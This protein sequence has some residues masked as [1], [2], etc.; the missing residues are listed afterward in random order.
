[1]TAGASDRLPDPLVDVLV[2]SGTL[3]PEAARAALDRQVMH[4]GALDTALLEVGVPENSILAAMTEVYEQPMATRPELEGLDDPRALR[5]IPEQW[6]QRHRLPP[7]RLVDGGRTLVVLSPAPADL[8]LVARLSELLDVAVVPH[9]A[10]EVRVVAALSRLYGTKPP[11]RYLPLL[12]QTARAT[13]HEASA[14]EPLAFSEASARLRAP[15]NRH[16]IARALLG[17]A[18][19][20]LAFGS[21][22]VVKDDRLEG[23]VGFGA[24]SDRIASSEVPIAPGSA[25]R[26]VIESRA[27]YLG[28]S[29]T[30][31]TQGALLG[32]LGRRPPRSVL[33]VPLRVRNRVVALFHGENGPDAIPGR[34]AGD[35]MLLV[36][37][38]QTAF[39]QLLLRQ[40]AESLSQLSRAP[41]PG[42]DGTIESGEPLPDEVLEFEEPVHEASEPPTR[43]A[44]EPAEPQRAVGAVVADD[45]SAS[46]EEHP[47]LP[48]PEPNDAEPAGGDPPSAA[49][50]E[51]EA[52]GPPPDSAPRDPTA[53]LPD[54]PMPSV[55][56]PEEDWEPVE[57]AEGDYARGY[58]LVVPRVLSDDEAAAAVEASVAVAPED[59]SRLQPEV[60]PIVPDVAPDM[61]SD[62]LRLVPS[63]LAPRP[64][65]AGTEDSDD[66]WDVAGEPT[67]STRPPSEGQVPVEVPSPARSTEEEEED[68][69]PTFPTMRRESGARGDDAAR[70]A[71]PSPE[72]RS[73][74]PAWTAP[75][76]DLPSPGAVED[77]GLV[78]I[79]PPVPAAP[80]ASEPATARVGAAAQDGADDPLQGPSE[81]DAFHPDPPA[82]ESTDDIEEALWAEA[83]RGLA[84]SLLDE[85]RSESMVVEASSAE[86]ESEPSGGAGDSADRAET[87]ER[88]APAESNTWS[89]PSLGLPPIRASTAEAPTPSQPVLL[90]DRAGE[91]DAPDAGPVPSGAMESG[92]PEAAPDPAMIDRWLDRLGEPDVEARR[93]AQAQLAT[94][95]TA[96]LPRASDRFPGPLVVDPFQRKSV[97]PFEACGPL[98]G[99][100]A[101]L[102]PDAHPYVSRKLEAP[103]PRV[104]FYAAYFYS[105][106]HVPEVIPRLIQRLHDEEPRICMMAA[107]TLFGY[108]GHPDFNFVLE[109]LH[110]RL[111]ATSVAARRHSAYLIGLFR[112]VSAI[113]L[114]IDLL[115]RRDKNLVDVAQ[116]ALTEITKQQLGPRAS[117]WRSWL[118]RNRD[119]SRIAWLID[120]LSARDEGVRRSAAEELRAVTG[121]D[122]GFEPDA[123]RRRR[124][125]ARQ[126]WVD[127]W[128]R[129]ERAPR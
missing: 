96:I 68:D 98:L 79:E 73:D 100:I 99:L 15:A 128:A 117:K 74:D 8:D 26:V 127:W 124:E 39:E 10:L 4:G 81:P 65:T 63:E 87:E 60:P 95:G 126:K 103:D 78:E 85:P 93:E 29:P 90:V 57:V 2:R 69:E 16:D 31:D 18:L 61:G 123:P 106:A 71:S 83:G 108:R 12:V 111:S 66:L 116:D 121:Q 35:I 77:D 37:Q 45:A 50:A 67:V 52:D 55:D 104:R 125:E 19:R 44:P 32:A 54:E 11:A 62:G 107:R 46:L 112:D 33:M 102:G 47:T 70:P 51:T 89:A 97:P 48:E 41:E 25:A 9:L 118:E 122:F 14:P 23:W 21:L 114:L 3:T 30:D 75:T 58:E 38:V 7:V 86:A 105:S 56:E 129:R 17:F 1:M 13:P 113:P 76:P 109:H 27:H 36:S 34:L 49:P 120:G 53:S 80:G 59:S 101:R 20:E 6:A 24:G 84:E 43:L 92:G 91:D 94:L 115:E 82:L 119:R 88:W 64:L 28:P 5:A 72:P 22:W 42:D 40:K 110:G